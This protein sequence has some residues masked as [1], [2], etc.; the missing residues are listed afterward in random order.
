MSILVQVSSLALRGAAKAAGEMAGVG[1][2]GVATEAVVGVLARRFTDQSQRLN[3]ALERASGRAWRA[4]EVAL[5]GTSWW[6]QCKLA[7]TGASERA[8]RRQVQAF[9]ER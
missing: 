9:L 5:A 4:V 7:L 1:A 2:A 3:R 6:D 8:F